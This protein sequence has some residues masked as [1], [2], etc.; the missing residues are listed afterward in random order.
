V[1]L[2]IPVLADNV[3]EVIECEVTDAHEV[4]EAHRAAH[5]LYTTC[6]PASTLPFRNFILAHIKTTWN[7][8]DRNT[9]A[10]A[11]EI[12]RRLGLRVLLCRLHTFK[13]LEEGDQQDAPGGELAADESTR[14]WSRDGGALMP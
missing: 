14:W 11:S 8:A 10:V 1:Q 9:K 7:F 5:A 2:K 12:F 3:V 6:I 4:Y 13:Q